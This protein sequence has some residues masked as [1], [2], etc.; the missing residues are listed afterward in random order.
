MKTRGKGDGDILHDKI[1]SRTRKN[2]YRRRTRDNER[3]L[4]TLNERVIDQG[5]NA[6][7]LKRRCKV[8]IADA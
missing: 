6:Y 7:E 3:S 2:N 4:V 8:E 1:V 5:N